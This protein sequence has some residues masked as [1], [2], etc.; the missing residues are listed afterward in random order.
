MK[1]INLDPIRSDEDTAALSGTFLTDDECRILVSE[2]TTVLNEKG[3]ILLIYLP[4][5][6]PL[7]Q[8]K[9]AYQP[10][11]DGATKYGGAS[12][13][14]IAQ[15][16]GRIV[17][18]DG[19]SVALLNQDGTRARPI[20][21]DGT[22]SNTS[23]S[24][25][26]GR[27]LSLVEKFNA[28]LELR[29]SDGSYKVSS[30][31]PDQFGVIGY[32][33]RSARFPY[34]RLTAYSLNNHSDFLN[35]IPYIQTVD[36]VFAE[37]MPARYAAQR[38]AIEQT[39]PHF[40]ISGTV[41]TTV[42][43]NMSWQTAVHTDKGDYR[44]RFGVL[45]CIRK[46]KYSGGYLVLPK[47]GV[48][49]DMRTGGILLVNVHEWH[50]NTKLYPHGRYERLSQVFY[51]REKMLECGTPQEELER[52]KRQKGNSHVDMDKRNGTNG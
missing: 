41:F 51:Y 9:A 25:R 35:A 37:Y 45:T 14:G 20:K 2:E 7:A 39:D 31:V 5:R 15:G 28:R 49:V 26:S 18:E 10:F 21:L 46:G 40:Y 17:S 30:L 50:G 27:I 32:A 3:E 36:S 4:N 44:P 1:T 11:K 52:A 34:C 16:R 42:T 24:L 43:V 12:N 8:I 19:V 6:I 29:Q 33:D 13:R 22:F 47:Y 38:A 23:Y 48:G